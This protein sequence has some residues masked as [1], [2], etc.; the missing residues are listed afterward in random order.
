MNDETE[1]NAHAIGNAR[2]WAA[3]IA[4]AIA[5][6]EALEDGEERAEFDGE[7]FTDAD[8]LRQRIEEMPLAIAVRDGWRSPGE[9]RADPEEFE[10]LLSTGGPALRIFGDIGGAHSLQWQDW[11][12][13]WTDFHETTT[14]QDEAIERFVGLFW[15]GE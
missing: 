13:P 4:S 11:F 9:E 8:E 2:A 6:L 1:R 5:A 7:E 3:N 14:E 15:F 12:T 10:I